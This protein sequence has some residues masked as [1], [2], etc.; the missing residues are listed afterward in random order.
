MRR[1]AVDALGQAEI[2]DV[3]LIMA[4]D[5][6]IRRLQIAVQ[7]SLLMGVVHGP[8]DLGDVAGCL[9]AL[10]RERALGERAEARLSRPG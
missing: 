3:Y 5:E 4:V 1:F 10:Q 8:G 7:D 2:G 6:H 9:L